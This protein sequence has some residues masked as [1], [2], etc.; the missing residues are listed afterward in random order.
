MIRNYIITLASVIFILF[1]FNVFAAN[2]GTEKFKVIGPNNIVCSGSLVTLSSNGSVHD[3][4]QWFPAKHFNNNTLRTVTTNIRKTTEFMV[5][6]VDIHSHQADTAKIIVKVNEEKLDVL[7]ED[8]VCEGDSTHILL[9]PAYVSPVWS[10]GETTR[11]IWIKKAGIYHVEAQGKCNY[12]QGAIHVTSM[13]KPLEVITSFGSLDICKGEEVKLAAFGMV[14]QYKWSTGESGHEITVSETKEVKLTVFNHC[15]VATDTKK[16]VVHEV[17]ASFIPSKYHENVPFTLDLINASN[18]DASD[19][20]FINGKEFS[21]EEDA[22]VLIEEEGE[23][24]IELRRTSKYGCENK[25]KFSSVI[26]LPPVNP[27]LAAPENLIVVPNSFTPNGDGINDEFLFQSNFIFDIKFIVFD[28]WGQELYESE[29]GQSG[30]DGRIG[31][32]DFAPQ[33]KYI[34]VYNYIDL[35]EKPVTK[36]MELNLLR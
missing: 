5:V 33:G 10:N 15:G 27:V 17:D 34:V 9:P 26:A 4:Y 24:E 3:E 12:A 29:G 22:S 14:F 36:T 30:W 35:D 8:F 19:K 23:Y 13:S 25:M 28:R 21:V 16:V 11:G 31:N 1:S 18:T 6:K 20:W 7:G 2:G 32:G